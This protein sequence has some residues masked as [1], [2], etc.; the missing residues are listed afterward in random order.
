M[1]T[2]QIAHLHFNGNTAEA[3][4]FYQSVFGGELTIDKNQTESKDL[5]EQV[6]RVVLA[7]LRHEMLNITAC[8]N[9]TQNT[10][11]F[12]ISNKINHLCIVGYDEVTF[13][14]YFE[15]LA[16]GGNIDMPLKEQVWGDTFGMLTDRYGVH[17]IVNILSTIN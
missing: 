17:W 4:T 7:Q 12:H 14:K 10:G 3:M 11:A 13:S 9:N 16:R 15:E 5:Q 8:D 6:D 2:K 1:T